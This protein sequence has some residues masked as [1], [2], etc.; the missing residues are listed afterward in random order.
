MLLITCDK[1]SREGVLHC[2]GVNCVFQYYEEDVVLTNVKVSSMTGSEN[3]DILIDSSLLEYFKKNSW[4]KIF[5]TH[6]VFENIW[7]LYQNGDYL[8]Y[9][10]D[11]STVGVTSAIVKFEDWEED[12]GNCVEVFIKDLKL[13]IKSKNISIVFECLVSKETENVIS[14]H[15]DPKF[16]KRFTN[17]VCTLTIHED[18]PLIID[19]QDNTSYIST[20]VME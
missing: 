14:V 5:P 10:W 17:K 9:Q 1:I 20:I 4:V 16:L 6:L 13:F 8:E 11:P 2:E 3:V 12:L 7:Y 15:V 18:I 19:A